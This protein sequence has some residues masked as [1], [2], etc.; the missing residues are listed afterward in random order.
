MKQSGKALIA[1]LWFSI[2]LFGWSKIIRFEV[3]Q[4]SRDLAR[5]SLFDCRFRILSAFTLILCCATMIK[6]S[7]DPLTSSAPPEMEAVGEPY[8]ATGW[9][10][11]EPE[12]ILDRAETHSLTF[13]DHGDPTLYEQLMLEL[14]NR[15]RAD[16]GAE[17][18]RLGID[19]NQ[20]LDPGTIQDTPKQPLAAHPLLIQAARDHS[21]WMLDNNIFSHTGAG[22]SSVS[23]RIS[24]AGYP[25]SG[26]WS[27]GENIAWGGIHGTL[28]VL[29]YTITRHE[30]LFLSPGHR[31]NI[32]HD[33]FEEL[34]IG[35]LTGIF[36]H[37]STDH[38]ALMATQKFARSQGTP[39]PF[40]TGVAYYDFNGNGFYDINEPIRGLTVA[41]SGGAYYTET[42]PAG[43]YTLPVP[44]GAA[45]RTVTFSGLGFDAA[46]PITLEG[47]RNKKVDFI[48]LYQPPV[49]EGNENPTVGTANHYL[50]STVSG[51]TAYEIGVEQWIAPAKDSPA[52][53]DRVLD[54][55]SDSYTPLSFTVKH[56]GEAAY[57]LVHPQGIASETLTYINPFEVD[58]G[59]ELRFQSRL[60]IA[61]EDQIA[62]VQLSVDGGHS[63]QTLY[64]QH[65]YGE[66]HPGEGGFHLRTIALDEF[67]GK[68]VLLRFAYEFSRGYYYSQTS[69]NF[70]WFIDAV[71]FPGS[72]EVHTLE[73]DTLSAGE[74]FSYT[75][76]DD[77]K[78]WLTVQPL[79][80]DRRWPIGPSLEIN[81]VAAS[82][83]GA[84][85]QAIET[86]AGLP[87][88]T[89]INHPDGDYSGDRVANMLAYVLGL[90]PLVYVADQLPGL[91]STP[92]GPVFSY[93]YDVT[94]TD[95]ILVP[96]IS[97][98]MSNWYA[99]GDPGIPLDI[100][101]LFSHIDGNIEHR[102]LTFSDDP[103]ASLF[104]RLRAEF[105][106]PG[107]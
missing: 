49:L 11:S 42:A 14:V 46:V 97:L 66:G 68:R 45:N 35:I 19:L 71:E 92:T 102:N 101:D 73:V 9:A 81:P 103:P 84:W 80:F 58:A 105:L 5:R 86:E 55:T 52:D 69:D 98:N 41:V 72:R 94:A 43:G 27:V 90:D 13:Y 18:D 70:G 24:A 38:D 36:T 61:T 44:D 74:S 10:E 48:P 60:R 96:E 47:G 8:F 25:L 26:S 87:A 104:I 33:G 39:D 21:Q 59:A 79:H 64:E 76:S 65:G 6:A 32:C 57:H 23:D 53:L 22:G 31:E 75:P 37:N 99:P 107:R 2:L 56:E 7:S 54:G 67:A 78:L 88:G 28:D 106:N 91:K 40:I 82:S 15:A 17:A 3:L 29:A 83:Y 20:G 50:F 85:A 93:W 89:L 1:G 12:T 63:W 16:P 62:R 30:G 34:G 77:R 4:A 51:A 95:V 100:D